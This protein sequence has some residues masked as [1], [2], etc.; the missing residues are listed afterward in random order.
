MKTRTRN[1][2]NL[3]E[4]AIVL[5]VVGL[6]IGG[7]WVAAASYVRSSKI[8]KYVH[9]L[10]SIHSCIV[11]KFPRLDC[12]TVLCNGTTYDQTT[13][14]INV[15]C[16]PEGYLKKGTDRYL[17]TFG[18]YFDIRLGIYGGLNPNI[19]I[20]IGYP[21]IN[22]YTFTPSECTQVASR[23]Y[24]MAKRINSLSKTV[25]YVQVGIHT[26]G[27]SGNFTVENWKSYCETDG[28]SIAVLF[29]SY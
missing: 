6:I 4:S 2:F 26:H 13:F 12:D 23:I 20:S 11:Q 28:T 19:R 18:N 21:R 8:E 17:D 7:I 14:F 10:F 22:G 3:I 29:Q 9:D 1:A 25:R 15:G 24:S 27:L 16:V 5:G